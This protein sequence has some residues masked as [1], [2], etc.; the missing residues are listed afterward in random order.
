MYNPQHACIQSERSP[1]FRWWRC[2]HGPGEQDRMK[3]PQS[4]GSWMAGFW[5]VCSQPRTDPEKP[6]R[7]VGEPTSNEVTHL[8]LSPASGQQQSEPTPVKPRAFTGFA[9]THFLFGVSKDKASVWCVKWQHRK[10]VVGP[11][12]Q[13]AQFSLPDSETGLP[14]RSF[15]GTKTFLWVLSSP[16]GAPHEVTALSF[17][18][19]RG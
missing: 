16:G 9:H 3:S 18:G 7:A 17:T 4:H 13:M 15:H 2:V 5:S 6:F 1:P 10:S 12:Q 8:V 14:S 11:D 19:A